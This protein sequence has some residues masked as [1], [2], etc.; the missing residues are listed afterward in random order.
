[1]KNVLKTIALRTGKRLEISDVSR[2]VRK[3]VDGSGIKNGLVNVWIP[4][5]TAGLAVNEHDPDL[6]DDILSTMTKLVPIEASYR[7]NAK[8]WSL[9]REQ[10]AHAHIL[11][12]MIKPDLTIPLKE[13]KM[14]LG[15]WQ[16]ILFIELDGPRNRSLHVQVLGE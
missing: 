5:T 6:W 7:H 10:N 8:Y 1:M 9:S 4:H 13:G 14:V 11:D 2:D 15:T 12:C 3:V 16:S